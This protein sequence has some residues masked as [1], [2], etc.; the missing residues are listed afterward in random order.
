MT[1]DLDVDERGDIICFPLVRCLVK[2]PF[3]TAVLAQLEYARDDAELERGL[4]GGALPRLQLALSPVQCRGLAQDLLAAAAEL[5][6]PR[7]AGT[8]LN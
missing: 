1:P 5:E 2:S 7:P 6:R 8:P 3:G 4:L